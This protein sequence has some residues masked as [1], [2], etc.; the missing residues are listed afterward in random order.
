MYYTMLYLARGY[1]ELQDQAAESPASENA[2][3]DLKRDYP[4][5]V[6]ALKTMP[7]TDDEEERHILR[8]RT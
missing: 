2:L 7:R 8:G 1:I 5:T 6:E 4:K 3:S